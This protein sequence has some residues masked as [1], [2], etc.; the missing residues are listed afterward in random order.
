MWAF[1]ESFRPLVS[2]TFSTSAHRYLILQ[3]IKKA[4]ELLTTSDLPL[5]EVGLESGF[6]DQAAFSR[7]FKALVG[8]SPRKWQREITHRP[9][10]VR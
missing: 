3:R 4:K 5:S 8:A 7:A 1:G 9:S 2:T 10:Y 6:T